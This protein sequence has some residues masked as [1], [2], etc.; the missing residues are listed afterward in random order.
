MMAEAAGGSAEDAAAVLAVEETSS[1]AQK[2]VGTVV[3]PTITATSGV[4]SLVQSDAAASMTSFLH[5]LATERMCAAPTNAA[6]AAAARAAEGEIMWLSTFWFGP[7]S[8]KH[9]VQFAIEGHCSVRVT[10]DLATGSAE[11]FQAHWTKQLAAAL[12]KCEVEDLGAM[13]ASRLWEAIPEEDGS[14]RGR[15][16]LATMEK[17]LG[18]KVALQALIRNAHHA[19]PSRL[20]HHAHHVRRVRHVRPYAPCAPCARSSR[21]PSARMTT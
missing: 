11:A 2:A 8:R 12:K 20:S 9:G 7:Q 13:D 14:G 16:D 15:V 17:D 3:E 4:S 5:N 10:G 21:W 19:H 18:I 1:N 6:R